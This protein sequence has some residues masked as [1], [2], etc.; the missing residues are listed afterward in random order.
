[1]KNPMKV[2]VL[3]AGV[4]GV[5]TAWFLAKAGREV[6]VIDRRRKPASKPAMPMA[7]RFPVSQSERGQ[8]GTPMRALKWMSKEDRP[9]AVSLA[10]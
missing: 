9:A 4:V 1:M 10:L 5:S 8:P 3:G 2:V 7:A 6:I